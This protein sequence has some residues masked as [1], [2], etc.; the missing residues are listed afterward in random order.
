MAKLN[1]RSGGG[2]A[3][4]WVTIFCTTTKQHSVHGNQLPFSGLGLYR[5]ALKITILFIFY[6]TVT[7]QSRTSEAVVRR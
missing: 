6:E 1:G 4:D 3:S 2:T 5:A 7:Q